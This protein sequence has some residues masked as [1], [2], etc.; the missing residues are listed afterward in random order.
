MEHV[1]AIAT[2]DD[3]L[4]DVAQ[5]WCA[6]TGATPVGVDTPDGA[7]R[8]WRRAA[9][10]LIGDDMVQ[11]IAQMRAPRRDHVVVVTRDPDAVWRHAVDLGASDVVDPLDDAAG[12][13]AVGV[14]LDGRV[15][16]CTVSVVGGSGGVGASTF[17]AALGLVGARRG[18]A[19]VLLDADP[20]GAGV[21]LLLGSE[22]AT[23]LRWT[24]LAAVD[25]RVS[26]DSLADVLPRHHN[27]ATVSWPAAEMAV[28]VPGAAG[29][30]WSAASRAFDLVVADAPRT[31][32]SSGWSESLLAGSVLTVVV[33]GE[34]VGG[35]GAARR[36]ASRVRETCSSVVAVSVT[37]RGG[38]G[39]SAAQE[40]IGLPVVA[41]IR[42][43]RGLRLAIDHG[44]GP[45]RSRSLRR[46]AGD[47]LDLLGLDPGGA[48]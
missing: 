34:D 19:A 44:R 21:E 11:E 20:G 47:V 33:V 1:A 25:G 13:R 17:A 22:R 31:V 48:S 8:E 42:P 24:D 3:Q 35:V 38:L 46:A 4:L 5:R 30:V 27:L 28:Q 14:A 23:G 37:R 2:S 43:H 39:S 6:A 15:E 45:M 9:V 36:V 12:L 41:R 40:A 10:M 26:G 16:G 7:R 18:L 29:A 32:G